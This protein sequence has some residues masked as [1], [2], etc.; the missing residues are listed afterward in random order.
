MS[1]PSFMSQK[2][3][4][5]KNLQIFYFQNILLKKSGSSTL[6]KPVLNSL[7]EAFEVATFG[8]SHTHQLLERSSKV[9]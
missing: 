9:F 8:D 5:R 2:N 7:T 1:A 3:Y 4:K 6:E